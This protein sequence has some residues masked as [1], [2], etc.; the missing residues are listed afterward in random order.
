MSA[1]VMYHPQQYVRMMDEVRARILEDRPV[2]WGPSLKIGLQMNYN[3]L[4]ACVEEDAIHPDFE[5]SLSK[6][7]PAALPSPCCRCPVPL[8]PRGTAF[9]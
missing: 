8:M 2:T 3:K 6:A 5:K 1:T 9:T 4:C 7:L